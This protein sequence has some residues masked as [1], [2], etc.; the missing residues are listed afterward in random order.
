M[1]GEKYNGVEGRE[2][3]KRLTVKK[4]RKGEEITEEGR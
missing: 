1:K 3:E 4:G 2:R